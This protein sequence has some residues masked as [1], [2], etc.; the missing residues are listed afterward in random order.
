MHFIWYLFSLSLLDTD[1]YITAVP[2][3]QT[4]KCPC[5]PGYI[6]L[7]KF[8]SIKR[9]LSRKPHYRVFTECLWDYTPC[10]DDGLAPASM[11]PIVTVCDRPASTFRFVASGETRQKPLKSPSMERG[12]Q[13]WIL[14]S[15]RFWIEQF[16]HFYLVCKFWDIAL[17]SLKYILVI[18]TYMYAN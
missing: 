2:C 7:S 10:T 5:G 8:R 4:S 12:F 6:I 18:D 14:D 13:S 1:E 15:T 9:C 17:L 11:I 16:Q 3:F